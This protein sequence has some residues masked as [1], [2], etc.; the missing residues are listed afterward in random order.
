MTRAGFHPN[1]PIIEIADIFRRHGQGYARAHAAHL[2]RVERRVMSAITTCRT[3]ALGGHVEACDACGV[4]RIAYNSCR[5][6]HCPKCQG[7]ARAKW[8][9]DRQAELLPVPYFHIVF[10]LP[11][12]I[13][14]IAF[15]NK[16]VVYAILFKAAA[17][18][19]T[20]LA[21]NPRRLGAR[22]G[23]LAILHTWGQ[24]LT[25][26]PHIHC[27]VPGG[28]LSFDGTRWVAQRPSFFLAI[29]PLSRLFRRLFLERLQALFEAG[30]LGFFNA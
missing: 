25:H 21:A 5:N 17:D 7:Q 22:I 1:R 24:A 18:A 14:E 30:M 15:Q 20:A 26:H 13:A 19:M 9:A 11:A 23:G 2:G 29:K 10:T 12:P 3:A 8:V 28:G 6:R 27:V 16:A 4:S